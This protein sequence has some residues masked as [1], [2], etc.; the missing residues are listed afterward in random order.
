[1]TMFV[2][3]KE[4]KLHDAVTKN[5]IKEINRLI[6]EKADIT[7]FRRFQN[8]WQKVCSGEAVE[9]LHKAGLDITLRGWHG[10]APLHFNAN[11]EVTAALI[12]AGAD[13][14]AQNDKLET[15]LHTV[16][17]AQ[18]A[19]LLLKSGADI[20]LVNE[21]GETPLMTHLRSYS[22][23]KSAEAERRETRDII[24]TILANT[25]DKPLYL[26]AEVLAEQEELINKWRTNPGNERAF[27]KVLKELKRESNSVDNISANPD[28]TLK[29]TIRQSTEKDLSDNEVLQTLRNVATLTN[30][31]MTEKLT[32]AANKNGKQY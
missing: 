1:M 11:P 30:T 26:S 20:S 28:T 12:K 31:D 2:P 19:K 24:A 17:S 9:I 27:Q 22:S 18:S 7:S 8:L 4:D 25:Y 29:D 14:N 5:D 23:Y 13:V 32:G 6:Q 16:K 3:D 10:N 15:P 21:L